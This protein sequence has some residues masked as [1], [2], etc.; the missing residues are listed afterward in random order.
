MELLSSLPQ[1]T[2]DKLMR[3]VFFNIWRF[4]VWQPMF[5]WCWYVCLIYYFT[6][7]Y[8]VLMHSLMLFYAY[9]RRLVRLSVRPSVVLSGA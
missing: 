4:T 6:G 7:Q 9:S 3:Q 2:H 1:V 8:V 5:D